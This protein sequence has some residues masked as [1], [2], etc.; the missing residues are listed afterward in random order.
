M[1]FLLNRLFGG[2][3]GPLLRAGLGVVFLVA[4]LVESWKIVILAGAVF[5][6]WGL[7]GSI[8]LLTGRRSVRGG[9]SGVSGGSTGGNE[10]TRR[11]Q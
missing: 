2:R 11:G 4:G 7:V 9:G 3:Y 6:L 8:G 1:L 5:I 10:Q